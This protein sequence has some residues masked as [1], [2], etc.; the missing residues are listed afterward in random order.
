MPTHG[1]VPYRLG[2]REKGKGESEGKN[3]WNQ[4]ELQDHDD[5]IPENTSIRL[6]EHF[7][8]QYQG[9]LEKNDDKEKTFLVDEY[10][11]DHEN[12]LVEGVISTGD[13]GYASEL[14]DIETGEKTYDKDEDESE[15]LPF[16]FLFWIPETIEGELYQN[17]E[18]GIMVFQQINGR[19]FKTSFTKRFDEMYIQDA[20]ETM[21]EIRPVTTQDILQKVVDSERVL[22]AEFE[23]DEVPTSD[24]ERVTYVE[25]MD[26]H[27]TDRQSLVMKPKYGGSL[28]PIKNISEQLLR[29][30]GSYAEIVSDSVEDLK[31]TVKNQ[32]G[33]DET[34]SLIEDELRMKKELDP[35]AGH[36]DEGLPKTDY[37]STA[38]S[39]TINQALPQGEVKTLDH[40]THL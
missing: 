19:S 14:R 1:L 32:H 35:R 4:T 24:E 33:R 11:V 22:K 21:F 37:L 2:F 23:L 28:N 9:K 40:T 27:S 26:T 8:E 39:D 10:F 36:L 15:L 7:L 17:G 38:C 3:F 34:F 13:Y 30:G 29:D 25:G 20:D 12:R 6:L 31:V 5:S 18:R 16:Y